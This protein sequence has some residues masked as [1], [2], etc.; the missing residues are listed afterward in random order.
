MSLCSSSST[1]TTSPCE[2]TTRSLPHQAHTRTPHSVPLLPRPNATV[3]CWESTAAIVATYP[4]CSAS[5]KTRYSPT[6]TLMRHVNQK[7]KG[8]PSSFSSSSVL[9][10]MTIS[11]SKTPCI[12][13]N[14]P[15]HM[16]SWI[17]PSWGVPEAVPHHQR[18]LLPPPSPRAQTT[19]I[20]EFSFP[21]S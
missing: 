18:P 14:I 17:T 16:T 2:C 21:S 4:P 7:C 9:Q 10:H 12:I 20:S 11:P 19:P 8:H 5:S 3:F 15:L 13:I 6:E 1:S